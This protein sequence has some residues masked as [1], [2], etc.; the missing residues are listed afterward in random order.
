MRNQYA[1]AGLVALLNILAPAAANASTITQVVD[2]LNPS[3]PPDPFNLGMHGPG[4]TSFSQFNPAAGTLNGVTFSFVNSEYVYATLVYGGGS[5]H[6]SD[7]KDE[8]E[9]QLLDPAGHAFIYLDRWEFAINPLGIGSSA[10]GGIETFTPAPNTALSQYI[11]VGTL[12]L[13]YGVGR[14]NFGDYVAGLT[15]WCLPSLGCVGPMSFNAIPQVAITYDYTPAAT[16]LPATFPLFATG[17]AGL[18]WLVRRRRKQ[19][20]A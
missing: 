9:Y 17:L 12:A 20:S 13:I 18:G 19:A 5:S 16:P 6:N 3:L 4:S 10:G 14:D 7:G 2:L 11:G 1:M 15:A 8:V